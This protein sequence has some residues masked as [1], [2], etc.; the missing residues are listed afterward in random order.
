MRPGYIIG[1]SHVFAFMLL[2][3]FSGC[4]NR[5]SANP[6]PTIT[7]DLSFKA[8]PTDLWQIGYSADNT[9]SLDQFRLST[10]ADTSNVIALWHPDANASSGYYPYVGQNRDKVSRQSP[11]NG[12]AVRAGQIPM[13]ASNS[14]QY[15]LVRFIVPVN[16]TYNLKAVFEG[17][18]FALSTTDVHI[19]VNSKQVFG[20]IIEGYGGDPAFHTIE[21]AYPSTSFESTLPL[22]KNDI[23]TFA[24]GYGQNQNHFGDTTGLLIFLELL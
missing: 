1:L 22:K 12:W 13:E 17:V 11:T 21:G 7:M 9:L 20:D 2:A 4:K 24:T 6:N 14:G 10:F 16:G 15:S 18:H 8:N 23:I 3:F 19:L 5:T